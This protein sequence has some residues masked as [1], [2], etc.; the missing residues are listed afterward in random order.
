MGKNKCLFVAFAALV[1][2]ISILPAKKNGTTIPFE[3]DGGNVLENPATCANQFCHDISGGSSL[4]ELGTVSFLNKPDTYIP[5][6]TYE[7]G[8]VIT[9][10]QFVPPGT[11]RGF[12]FQ[13]A[14]FLSDQT[15]AGNL[16]GI[17]PGV[18]TVQAGDINFLTHPDR[19]PSGSVDFLWTAPEAGSGSVTMRI[20]ANASN[21]N[22]MS[23]GDAISTNESIIFEGE[24]DNIV[25]YFPQI[26]VGTT[27]T[28]TFATDLIFVNTGPDTSLLVKIFQSSGDPMTVQINSSR[29]DTVIGNLTQLNLLQ[30]ATAKLELR[31]LEEISP[32][33][34]QV[35]TGT[36]VGGV[37]IFSLF[38]N[39]IAEA[40]PQTLSE[41]GVPSANPLQD[42]SLSVQVI[43]DVSDTG[44]AI[45]NPKEIAGQSAS[46]MVNEI[47][48]SLYSQDFELLETITLFL[49]PG[50]QRPRFL[51]QLFS[52]LSGEGIDFQG[53]LTVRCNE[54]VAVV[55]LRQNSALTLT[56]LPVL[57]GRADQE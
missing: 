29:G 19:L 17:T 39:P 40:S 48:L 14:T 10:E 53:S 3:A 34:V 33:Y 57:S 21:S 49:E 1:L 36:Q 5:G 24:N 55:T 12:G 16:T 6:Q 52:A 31:G 35:I 28:T 47:T 9:G 44:L 43:S 13:L 7:L 20:A 54:P 56:A 8:L 11:S 45:V 25:Y 37:A 22:N 42:F 51:S 26:G 23:S 41:S 27:G 15:Q 2:T 18:T 38:T 32:G 46:T 50:E 30:G 4:N